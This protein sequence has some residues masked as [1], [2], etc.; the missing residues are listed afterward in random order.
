M[1]IGDTQ[2]CFKGTLVAFVG[3][4]PGVNMVGGFKEGVNMA[5]RK[6]RHCMATYNQIQS[7]VRGLAYMALG[8][9]F[10]I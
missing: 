7:K 1:T 3:D 9:M 8:W 10:F 6:C 2:H 4:T 5:M